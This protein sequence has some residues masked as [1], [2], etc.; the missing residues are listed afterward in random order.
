MQHHQHQVGLSA[1]QIKICGLTR[2]DEAVACVQLGAHA[3]G[4]VFY[5]KSPR[6]V[7]IEQAARI[8]R[9]LPSDRVKTVGVFVDESYDTIMRIV[10]ACRLTAVQLHG[11]ESPQRVQ[12]LRR[13]NLLVIK[14]LF[15]ARD[16]G[17][18]KA[19]A[20][21]P[22]AYLVECG[23]GMLPGGNARAWNWK[24][25]APFAATHPCILAGGLSPVNVEE[26]IAAALP[27]AVDVSSGVESAPG[28]KDISE[29]EHFITAVARCT[30]K[31][32]IRSI[33]DDN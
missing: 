7:T 10:N 28:R 18:K 30:L 11:Q 15:S 25:A 22:T 33:F 2:V 4:L 27:D 32:H 5:P 31:K 26:A 16:P 3:I 13:E 17:I 6:C 1:P 12:R 29:V 14:A 8:I 20:Y 23:R 21:D 9:A 19:D 24:E